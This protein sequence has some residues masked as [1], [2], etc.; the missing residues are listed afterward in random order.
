MTLLFGAAFVLLA[1]SSQ[2]WWFYFR[3]NFATHYPAKV[4]S[5]EAYREFRIP[6]WNRYAGAGQP[7]AGNPNLLTFYPD[8]VLYLFLPTR[9][10]FNLHFLLHLLGGALAMRALLRENGAR[11][12]AAKITT[13]LYLL[14]GIAVSSLNFYNL[15]CYF[16]LIPLAL[17]AV[18]R[19]LRLGE[20]R[21]ALLTGCALGLMGLAPEPVMVIATGAAVLVL[22]ARRLTVADLRNSALALILALF[23]AAPQ[24]IAYAEIAGEVER[25][26]YRYTPETVMAASLRPARLLELVA[27]PFLGL[28]TV[29]GTSGYQLDLHAAHP[30]LFNSLLI[31]AILIPALLHS[32]APRR[33]QIIAAIALFM[34]LGKFNP[35]VTALIRNFEELRIIRY[36]EK[37]MTLFAVAAMVLIGRWLSERS[38]TRAVRLGTVAAAILIAITAIVMAT[39]ASAPVRLRLVIGASLAVLALASVFRTPRT[40]APL[41]ILTF[42]PLLFWFVRAM[43]VDRVAPYELRPPPLGRIWRN[44]RGNLNPVAEDARIHYRRFA[45]SLVPIS[46]AAL[47]ISYAL[48]RSPE[49]M[50]SFLSRLVRDRLHLAEPAVAVRYLRLLS[51][52][53]VASLEELTLPRLAPVGAIDLG[54]Q[55]LFFYRV[56]DPVSPVRVVRRT[57]P[58]K[59]VQEAVARLESADFDETGEAIVPPGTQVPLGGARIAALPRGDGWDIDVDSEGG[60]TI[61][62][63]ETYFRGW[64]AHVGEKELSIV[65]LNIDRLGI[66]VPAGQSRIAVTFSRRRSWI[67]GSW[68]LSAVLLLSGAAV[69]SRKG[70]RGSWFETE[71]LLTERPERPQDRP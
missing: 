17:Y 5:A 33:Y 48:D 8:N 63:S 30:P 39:S 28:I 4:I 46:G 16:A 20:L 56:E 9:V 68:L 11:R 38:L 66:V 62:V 71:E 36:P 43:P 53:S 32:R 19:M 22:M 67:K 54:L 6:Y 24:L 58:V 21:S 57:F 7:L 2:F 70:K 3:D 65:P 12:T 34:A 23:I 50:Y 61:V 44:E 13:A 51:V 26:G 37:F 18:Q 64:R 69:A 15:V 52:N 1:W 60:S 10:A 35:I 40:L 25:A 31:G 55:S 49:G 59:S 29:F 14:S 42:L 47:G 41:L 45:R 27:G